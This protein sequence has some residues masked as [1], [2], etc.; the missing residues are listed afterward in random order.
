MSVA[1]QLYQLQE[2][3]LEL[4]SDEQALNEI[5]SQ[6][7]D[8]KAV[9]ETENKL[10]SERQHL[11]ELTHQQHS[12]EWE[13]ED[14]TTKLTTA[15]EEL[16]SG[17]IRNPKEL[18]NLQQEIDSLKVKRNKLEDQALEIMEKVELATKSVASLD[19]ELRRLKTEWQSQQQKL[20]TDLKQ[21]K[22]AIVN[23]RHKRELLAAEIDSQVT[24]IYHELKRQRGTA[25]ARVEQG[26]C[27]GC[28][29]SLPVTELQ[30]ARSGSLVRCS[31]CGRI[32]FLA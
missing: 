1:K 16:Y 28:R 20:S 19:S 15:E 2:V 14:I 31:S 30:R 24:E 29:I 32:L 4:E 9:I 3:D 26:I 23:L 12:V 13:I 7:G 8:S 11:E 18:T 5:A 17:R 6:L 21:L 22:A 10:A 27:R 25:V